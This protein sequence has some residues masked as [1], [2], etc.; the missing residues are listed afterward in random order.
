MWLYSHVMKFRD[1]TKQ[2]NL[3]FLEKIKFLLLSR[4]LGSP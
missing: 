3:L 1:I 2:A 4:G